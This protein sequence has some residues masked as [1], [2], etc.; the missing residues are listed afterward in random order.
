MT[1][2][3]KYICDF[4]KETKPSSS[5]TTIALGQYSFR[6]L[7]VVGYSRPESSLQVDGCRPCL[8]RIGIIKLF[9]PRE[10]GSPEVEKTAAEK[11]ED[12]IYEIAQDAVSNAE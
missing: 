8:E 11:I 9:K 2:E 5:L 1:T 12:L 6:E 10:D 3:K 7:M 4:C